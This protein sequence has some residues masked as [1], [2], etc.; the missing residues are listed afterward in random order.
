MGIRDEK[1]FTDGEMIAAFTLLLPAD[2]AQEHALGLNSF[3]D[4]HFEGEITSDDLRSAPA[5]GPRSYDDD[6]L[7]LLSM[8][9]NDVALRAW[10]LLGVSIEE[11]KRRRESFRLRMEPVLIRDPRSDW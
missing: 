4:L 9:S 7:D 11:G 5:A 2:A 1:S 6:I 10:R 3:P 8:V